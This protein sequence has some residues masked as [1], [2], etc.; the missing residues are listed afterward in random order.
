MDNKVNSNKHAVINANS[1]DVAEIRNED[2]LKEIQ[3]R[4]NRISVGS[5]LFEWCNNI[6]FLVLIGTRQAPKSKEQ[7]DAELDQYM[8]N[9]RTTADQEMN[10]Y[11]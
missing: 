11:K 7:L 2:D 8:V 9:T 3:V 5:M 10:R 6:N 4:C 1:K